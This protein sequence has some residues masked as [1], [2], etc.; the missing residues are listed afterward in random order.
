LS[1]QVLWQDWNGRAGIQFVDV[2]KFS[3][4]LL[5]DFL[6]A[7]VPESSRK[8]A[9]SAVEVEMEEPLQPVAV[10]ATSGED[11]HEKVGVREGSAPTSDA[12]NRRE[13]VRYSCRLGAEVYQTGIAVPNHCCLTDL[14]PGGCYL[15]V[16]LPFAKG[17][18][19]EIIVRTYNL[20]IQLRGTVQTSHPGYGMGIAFELKNNEQR[21]QV[22]KL[23]DLVAAGPLNS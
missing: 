21:D 17:T 2:P 23:M 5:S 18:S 22:K 14:G 4:R 8:D 11:G 15:E 12:G 9:V 7:H 13:Q 3:R 16:H 10:A 20:K 1:G 6:K 19:V